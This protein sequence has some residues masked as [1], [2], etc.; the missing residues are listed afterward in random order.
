MPRLNMSLEDRV[1]TK[2]VIDNE[3]G[4]WNYTGTIHTN[5]YGVISI[6]NKYFYV[7]RIAFTLKIGFLPVEEKVCHT[8]DNKIC[9]NPEHLYKGS[10]QDN[11]NDREKQKRVRVKLPRENKRFKL[12]SIEEK[13]EVRHSYR[14]GQKPKDIAIHFEIEESKIWEAILG[15]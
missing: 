10:Q 6:K 15:L 3:T 13:E 9:I 1:F 7:H 4:C 12:L 2:V 14:L 5:G 11:I 8:C